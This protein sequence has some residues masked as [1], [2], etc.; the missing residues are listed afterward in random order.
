MFFTQEAQNQL[1][2]CQGETQL[3]HDTRPALSSLLWL[4][5][6]H[7]SQSEASP[8]VERS[9]RLCNVDFIGADVDVI[10]AD[11]HV[12]VDV[13]IDVDV[14]VDVHLEAEDIERGDGDAQGR[15]EDE[16][17]SLERN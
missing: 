13:D 1:K 4:R 2:L 8:C 14:D 7:A 3:A 12:D 10:D 9:L 5:T 6:V 11:V 17:E 15:Q 16:V